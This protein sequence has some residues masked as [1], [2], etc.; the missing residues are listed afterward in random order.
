M[1]N[2]ILTN[3]TLLKVG[4]KILVQERI[5]SDWPG[6]TLPGGH[7]KKDE[8]LVDAAKR[9]FMEE[10]GLELLDIKPK[11]YYEWINNNQRE[12]SFLYIANSYKGELKSSDEGKVFFINED[13]ILNY[14][15]SLDFK[16]IYEVITGIKI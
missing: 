5:K 3:M 2:V 15:L 12:I 16:E 4:D 9:E 10:T 13:E 6:L 14:K 1:E 7:V 8:S 11:G